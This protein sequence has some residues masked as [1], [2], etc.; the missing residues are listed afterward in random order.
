[1]KRLIIISIFII[2]LLPTLLAQAPKYSNEF[3]A[4]GVGARALGMSNA[5]VS[6]VNDVTASY[7]NPAGLSLL[8]NDWQVAVM[9]SEYFA[10]IAKYDYA[11]VAT[12]IDDKSTIGVSIIR[13]GVDDIPNTTELIGSDGR[14]HYD[15]I[16][17][18]SAV[19]Y[20]FIFSLSRKTAVKG[21]RYG[22]NVKVIYRRIGDFAKAYGFGIDLGLQYDLKKWRFGAVAKDVTSTFNA[23]TFDISERTKEVFLST[24]NEI[25]ENSLEL[26]LPRLILG[27][28]KEFDLGKN[29]SSTANIDFDVTFDGKRNVLI[30]SDP[31]SVDPHLGLEFGYK[32]IVF[33]RAGVGNIQKETEF[34]GKTSTSFQPNIGVGIVIKNIVFIDYALTDIGDQSIALYSNVFSLKVNLNRNKSM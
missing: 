28:G 4:I 34:G 32:N 31:V 20:G 9:H 27:M 22:G 14:F 5:N 13:F 8:S 16:T 11:G 2:A 30:K 26:T 33:L 17:S 19:D 3:L 1:M 24:D 7:W 15:M 29:F 23:W 12:K 6:I 25:P 10:G 21:L 18:F